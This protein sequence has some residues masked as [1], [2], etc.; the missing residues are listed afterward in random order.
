MA[1][2]TITIAGDSALNLE[3]AKTISAET[4]AKIRMAAENLTADPIAGVT[5]L[6]PTFC[7]LMVYYN[8]LIVTFDELSAKLRGKLRDVE[9]A[10]LSVRKIVPIP[11]CYGGEF[12]PDLANVAE[13]AGMSEEEVIAIHT[14]R[15]YLIDMLG[16]LPGFAYLG[17]L[18]ERL[19]TPRLA[20]PR[21]RIEPGSVGIGGAQTGIYPLASP[22]G[23]QIIGRTPLRPY[24]PDREDPILYAAGE[25]LRFV[26]ITPEEYTAIE[27][28]LAA[29]TYSYGIFVEGE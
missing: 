3:F 25:Y 20:V 28:R 9:E 18:D 11:V 1:G 5:E 29:G 10:D 27:A 12:G 23:W 24:D 6:V 13:H 14:G 7:S 8:P 26:P 19:H 22:G 2:F 4:S 17:G 15:D 21:T 16:F